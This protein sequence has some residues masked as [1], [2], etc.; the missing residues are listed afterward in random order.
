MQNESLKYQNSRYQDRK[1]TDI[2]SARPH[3]E[4]LLFSQYDIEKLATALIVQ[5]MNPRIFFLQQN[6]PM[7]S[8]S[9]HMR[10]F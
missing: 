3:F 8:C 6:K 1:H 4:I 5:K 7:F 9:H 10:E 2:Q